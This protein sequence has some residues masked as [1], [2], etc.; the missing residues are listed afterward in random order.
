M[1]IYRSIIFHCSHLVDTG[2][3]FL[4]TNRVGSFDEAFKSRIHMHLYYPALN[5][6]Q[7]MQIWR[8]N[9]DRTMERK[10]DFMAID[11][12]GIMKYAEEHFNFNKDRNTRWNGRQ[13]RSAFQT[14]AALAEYDA[15]E[16]DE[17]E[18][19]RRRAAKDKGEPVSPIAL[20]RTTAKLQA[21][22]FVTVAE[23][24]HQFDEYLAEATGVTDSER[25]RLDRERADNFRW[26]AARSREVKNY[27]N[28]PIGS[29][30]RE[31]YPPPNP[32]P[33]NQRGN[34]NY[35]GMDLSEKPSDFRREQHY[36]Q[37]YNQ[38]PSPQPPQQGKGGYL[39]PQ[40]DPFAGESPRPRSSYE[41]G[42]WQ[43]SAYTKTPES[44]SAYGYGGPGGQMGGPPPGTGPGPRWV[45][46]QSQ[47]DD[48]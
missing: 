29:N 28:P 48:D 20:S 4:T 44:S 32:P 37:S 41:G 12:D 40:A 15:I 14:A 19:E 13:I 42:G 38:S 33:Y 31:T 39:A 24:S 16:K 17:K 47:H 5:R 11:E 6:D 27:Q 8:M 3:L 43:P 23:A 7:T 1:S 10:K 34:S 45:P 36:Y 35:G 21:S 25:A 18:E 9:M 2:I 26:T 22:H 46:A 30:G